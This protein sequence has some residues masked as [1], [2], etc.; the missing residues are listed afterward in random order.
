MADFAYGS[1]I[2]VNT[3]DKVSRKYIQAQH[4]QL[5]KEEEKEEKDNML[6]SLPPVSFAPLQ[7]CGRPALQAEQVA[8]RAESLLGHV[9]YS[10][11]WYN[12]EHF[13]MYC[14]Y[15]IVMSFQTFQVKV[16][17]HAG[18]IECIG[19]FANSQRSQSKQRKNVYRGNIWT[20]ILKYLARFVTKIKLK[21]ILFTKNLR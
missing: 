21:L 18:W 3:V 14:R 13:V 9:A 2:L 4:P 20:D 11:L 15:G 5:T 8:R 10:L 17:V 12:C 16:Q 6:V 19:E 1:P 7:V